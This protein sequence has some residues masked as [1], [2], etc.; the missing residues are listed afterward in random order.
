MKQVKAGFSIFVLLLFIS[1]LLFFFSQNPL[2]GVLQMITLPIQRMMFSASSPIIANTSM[3]QLQEENDQLRQQLAQLQEIK[4]D[5]TALHDQFKTT[6]PVPQKLLPADVV[7]LQQNALIIDKGQNDDVNVG[8]VIVFKNNLIGIVGKITP[9]LSLVTLLSDSSTSFT[10]ETT[11]TVTEGIIKSED[12]GVVTLDNVILSDKLEK[13][14]IV[15]TK[16]D[17]N[18]QGQGYPPHLVVGK[19]VSV[20]KQASSLFQSAKVASLV[21]ISDLKMVFV[22]TE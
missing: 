2:I 16:G 1:L 6:T 4:S 3:Q 5:D 17:Q 8:D 19:I 21:N 18:L 20:D 7:G 11:K 13:D 10:A 22:I 14:D 12:G 15:V 9:H